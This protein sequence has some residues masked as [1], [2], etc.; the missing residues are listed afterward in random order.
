MCPLAFLGL[1]ETKSRQVNG[2]S[3]GDY[4]CPSPAGAQPPGMR[5]ARQGRG[6][7]GK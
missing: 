2:L 3:L 5:R 7:A 4:S 1:D 6:S